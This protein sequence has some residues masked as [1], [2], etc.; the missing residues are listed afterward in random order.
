MLEIT[1]QNF[2]KEVLE[3]DLPVLVDFSAIWCGPC[4]MA[5]PVIEEL[6]E[7]YEGKLKVG[8]LDVDANSETAAKYKV[9]S[10]PTVVMFKKGK[11]VK[12]TVGFPGRAGYKE[13]IEEILK[14]E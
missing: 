6:A 14:E 8:K 13:L 10:M 12:R 5:G 7:E 11:E 9:M 2:K 3:A 1:D 4:Q